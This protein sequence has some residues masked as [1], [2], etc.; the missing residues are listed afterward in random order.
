MISPTQRLL[1]DITQHSEEIFMSPAEFEPFIPASE[2]PLTHVLDRAAAEVGVEF[3][4]PIEKLKLDKSP[5]IDKTAVEMV[6][7]REGKRYAPRY[8]N[9]LILCGIR[10]TCVSSIR[11]CDKGEK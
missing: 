1:P 9:L 3:E 6:Q 8:I 7:C 2:R 10:R 11:M 4:M 5:G